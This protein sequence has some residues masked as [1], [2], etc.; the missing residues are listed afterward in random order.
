[1][2]EL[3]YRLR[4]ARE[5]QGLELAQLAER[6]KVRRAILEA[7][8]ECRYDELPE[9]PLARGYLKRYAQA[10]GLDPKPLLMLYPASPAPTPTDELPPQSRIPTR[11]PRSSWLWV[12]PVLA[13]LGGGVFW[14]Y[15]ARQG[16]SNE[17][18]PTT[19][20]AP[21]VKRV[22]LRVNTEPAGARVY[23][24]GFLL[25]NAPIQA[26]VEVGERVLRVEAQGYVPK[27]QTLNL[28]A[29]QN[30]TVRLEAVKPS[31]APPNTSPQSTPQPSANTLVLR[32]EQPSWI[33]VT[34]LDGRQLYEGIAPA[35]TQLTYPLPVNV[36]TGNAGGV[37]VIVQGQDQGLMG[38]VGQVVQRRFDSPPTSNP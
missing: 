1:M 30:L 16:H 17:A 33:R 12:L 20:V 19:Q 35:G 24:D 31:P 2:C 23:L 25:G 10:L 4:Q 18:T 13:L 32:I 28:F 3:G 21:V 26:P 27:Q 38:A 29:D 5:E 22:V 11:T 37:R 7:L 15:S 8:E 9:P 36:R 14:W 34:S 6:L